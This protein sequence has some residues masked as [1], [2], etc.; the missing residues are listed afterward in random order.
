MSNLMTQMRANQL[1]VCFKGSGLD[2]YYS[3]DEGATWSLIKSMTASGDLDPEKL[4]FRKSG[5]KIRLRFRNNEAKEW[6]YFSRGNLHWRQG[7]R[8]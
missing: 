3:T 7:G 6:F 1:D 2:A 5:E 4:N 8:L